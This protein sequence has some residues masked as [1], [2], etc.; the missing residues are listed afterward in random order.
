MRIGTPKAKRYFGQG[1][2]VLIEK[3]GIEMYF[4]EGKVCENPFMECVCYSMRCKVSRRS[5]PFLLGDYI[6]NMS[7]TSII[8]RSFMYVSE[9]SGSKVL[10]SKLEY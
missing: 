10:N 6:I 7:W 3:T 4:L 5:L 9:H 2:L 8:S 1:S